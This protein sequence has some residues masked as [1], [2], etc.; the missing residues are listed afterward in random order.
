VLSGAGFLIKEYL[1]ISVGEDFEIPYLLDWR[2]F[3]CLKGEVEGVLTPKKVSGDNSV[4]QVPFCVQ[5]ACIS[6]V[7]KH[8]TTFQ[9]GGAT[10]KLDETWQKDLF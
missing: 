3:L 1:K 2:G 10:D 6:F 4:A 5:K 7:T 9:K 8:P